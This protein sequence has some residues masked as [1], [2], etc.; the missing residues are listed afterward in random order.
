[1]HNFSILSANIEGEDIKV[2]MLLPKLGKNIKEEVLTRMLKRYP[3][4]AVVLPFVDLSGSALIIPEVAKLFPKIT[5]IAI[6]SN[7]KCKG[8]EEYRNHGIPNMKVFTMSVFKGKVKIVGENYQRMG[9]KYDGKYVALKDIN[10]IVESIVPTFGLDAHIFGV[11]V[12]HHLFMFEMISHFKVA[13]QAVD[14]NTIK[15]IMIVGGTANTCE[16]MCLAIQSVHP[17]VIVTEV[18]GNFNK[19]RRAFSSNVEFFWPDVPYTTEFTPAM[20]DFNPRLQAI[21]E[22]LIELNPEFACDPYCGKLFFGYKFLGTE[23]DISSTLHVFVRNG[24]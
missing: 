17:Q 24:K 6:I 21:A 18:G 1:M 3:K 9:P 22:S 13:F 16:A 4:D 11:G 14:F 19:N 12:E 7:G 5:F 10:R 8:I 2:P 20:L 23:A 15:R